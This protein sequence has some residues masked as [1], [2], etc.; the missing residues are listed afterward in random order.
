MEEKEAFDTC[1]VLCIHEDVVQELKNKLLDK[2]TVLSLA[3]TFK[4]LGDPTRVQII[5]A[6]A[7]KELCVCDLAALLGMS[8]SAISHQLRIL[9]NLRLVKYRKEGKIVYYSI[10]DQ[11]IIN[12]FTEGLEHI[13]HG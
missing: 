4:V 5:H 1:A 12:L 6:L 2:N 10:D 7:Q 11:H 9:R 13:K 3:E 8:Q